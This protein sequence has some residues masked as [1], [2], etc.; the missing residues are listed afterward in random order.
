MNG[1]ELLR[2]AGLLVASGWCQ[3]TE[4]RTA[5]GLPVGVCD[6]TAD[7]WSLLGALQAAA[8]R[9]D[10]TRIEDVGLAVA[11]LAELISDPSL[12]DWNDDSARTQAGVA[13]VLSRAEALARDTIA[14]NIVLN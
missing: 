12:A 6:D 11:A 9:D 10:S 7:C 13:L 3:G 14:L 5:D 1:S 4:A 2:V 8:M